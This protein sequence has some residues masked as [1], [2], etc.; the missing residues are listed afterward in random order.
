MSNQSQRPMVPVTVVTPNPMQITLT[1]NLMDKLGIVYSVERSDNKEE[2]I[3]FI[4][5]GDTNISMADAF[6]YLLDIYES[7]V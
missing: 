7:E 4:K 3:K 5:F 1:M 6:N 2:Y